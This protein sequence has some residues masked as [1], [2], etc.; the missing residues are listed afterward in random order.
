MSVDNTQNA[1]G[2]PLAGAA[3]LETREQT[4]R[5]GFCKDCDY[6]E[7][8]DAVGEI[9]YQPSN[10]LGWC[11]GFGKLTE[12]TNGIRCVGFLEKLPNAERSATEAGQ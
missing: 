9:G 5:I 6:W 1:A 7:Q 2:T 10:G 11:I 3:G 12:G 8:R 4:H